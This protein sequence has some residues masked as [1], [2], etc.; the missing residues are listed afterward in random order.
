MDLAVKEHWPEHTAK[1]LSMPT[2]PSIVASPQDSGSI[3]L[4]FRQFYI[5][6]VECLMDT[7]GP[8]DTKLNVDVVLTVPSCRRSISAAR[9]QCI[10]RARRCLRRNPL[11]PL[12]GEPWPEALDYRQRVRRCPD[13]T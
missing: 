1:S 9:P 8:R 10:L 12:A 2:F 4:L 3:M 13:K 11:S 6:K 5:L 7:P